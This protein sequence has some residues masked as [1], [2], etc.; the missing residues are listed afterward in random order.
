[1]NNDHD[2]YLGTVLPF[3]SQ[4]LQIFIYVDLAMSGIR[5]NTYNNTLRA[6]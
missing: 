5:R 4:G 2:R 6:D 3:N 1:M